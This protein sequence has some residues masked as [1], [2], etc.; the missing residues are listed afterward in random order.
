M[1]IFKVT[2][3]ETE[4]KTIVAYV[5]A[6][7]EKVADLWAGSVADAEAH[8]SVTGI[9]DDGGTV[10][11]IERVDAA[12]PGVRVTTVA[13]VKRSDTSAMPPTSPTAA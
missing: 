1:P 4:T 10:E 8:G 7:D 11:D 9:D 3:T 2:M 13:R 12:P 6:P 5:D